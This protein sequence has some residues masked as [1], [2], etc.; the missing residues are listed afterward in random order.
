MQPGEQSIRAEIQSAVENMSK[1]GN[2]YQKKNFCSRIQTIDDL[3]FEMIGR[4]DT[5][6][7]DRDVFDKMSDLKEFAQRTKC[8]LESVN[9]KL[10]QQLRIKMSQ[11]EYR[12]ANLVK[13]MDEYV[14]NNPKE[15]LQPDTIGYDELDIFINGLLSYQIIPGETK[16]REPEMIYYQK[17]PVR[18]VLELIRRAE[19]KPQDVFIDLG[20]GLGQAVML[21]NLITG[22]HS[23]G[24][25]F[26]PAF[27]RYARA[28]A[29]ELHL[30]DVEF[31]TG[32][33][34]F[35]DYTGGTVFFMYT[36][37]EG[38]M[39]RETLQKLKGEAKKTK[40]RIFTYGPCTPVV[41]QQNW[42]H[43]VHEMKPESR[44][45]GEFHSL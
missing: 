9:S 43:G 16:A 2:L 39:L 31:R 10:F 18:I 35:A 22:V 8:K 40:I 13:L 32:D 44:G 19:F 7:E 36:P 24:L 42:L 15:I 25:E 38:K 33:A 29:A 34:R 6:M 28:L 5:L 17:T 26:E 21:V 4:I 20:S 27:C 37:F 23:I 3:E 45:L 1:N 12:G 41:A 14:D 11:G 30:E